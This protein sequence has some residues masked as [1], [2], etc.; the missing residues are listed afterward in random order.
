MKLTSLVRSGAVATKLAKPKMRGLLMGEI[1]KSI[2]ESFVVGV[3]ALVRNADEVF[4]W[5]SDM[6]MRSSLLFSPM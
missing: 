4:D 6:T 3:T 5:L 2:V 1:K